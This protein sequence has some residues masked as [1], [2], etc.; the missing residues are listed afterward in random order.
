M[1][2]RLDSP[3]APTTREGT[4]FWYREKIMTWWL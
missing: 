2:L 3:H 4:P 1:E